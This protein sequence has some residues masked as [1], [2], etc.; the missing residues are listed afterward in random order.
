MYV[1][2]Q[3]YRYPEGVRLPRNYGGSAFSEQSRA[4]ELTETEEASVTN[5]KNT[6]APISASATEGESAEAL[7]CREDKRGSSSL[8]IRGLGSEELLLFALI[9]LLSDS[10]IGDDL[11][12]FLI[13][14]FFI[15]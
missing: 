8:G 9:L 6:D 1:R 11:I 4:E 14:L 15:K 2:P 3:G 5:E 10:D 12:L 7:L 13:L